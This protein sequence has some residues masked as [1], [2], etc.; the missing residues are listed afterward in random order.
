MQYLNKKNQNS[1]DLVDFLDICKTQN[2][3]SD[4]ILSR[5]LSV[6]RL[7]SGPSVS[8]YDFKVVIVWPER[9]ISGNLSD[10]NQS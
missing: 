1:N 10:S 8:S 7:P 5:P 3:L 2:T 6:L 4:G 9:T